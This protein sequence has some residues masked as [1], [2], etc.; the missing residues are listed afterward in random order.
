MLWKLIKTELKPLQLS[1]AFLGGFMGLSIMLCA[2]MFYMDVS[3]VFKDKEGFWK[4]EYLIL[5]KKIMLNDTYQQS[6]TLDHDKP[7]FSPDEIESM[8][9]KPFIKELASFSY[10]TFK[11]AAYTESESLLSGFYSEL[12]FEAVPEKYIDVNYNNWKW[13][14][15]DEFIPVIVP[16]TY[17]NLYNFGFATTQNLPQVSEKSASLVSFK[18]KISGNGKSKNFSARIIGFSDRINTILVPEEFIKWGNK[19]Y[20]LDKEPRPSRLIVV[21]NDPSDPELFS[22]FKENNYDVNKSELSNSKALMFLRIV[23]SIILTIGLIIT[24]LAFWLMLTA[25]L[26]LLQR[27]KAHIIKLKIIGYSI[28]QIAKP[29][30]LISIVFYALICLLSFLPII[31]IRNFYHSKLSLL[32]YNAAESGLMPIVLIAC[33]CMI[34]MNAISFINIHLNVKKFN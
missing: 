17:L 27:N 18:V 21:A 25:I 29:Y 34:L 20:G 24:I 22:F 2:V 30:Y 12:F 28:E 5:S 19:N 33:I 16:K 8:R 15:D 7:A 31:F 13:N 9:Q 6:A 11:V 26:L 14:P 3:P 32:G 10:C 1:G 4:D 23:I